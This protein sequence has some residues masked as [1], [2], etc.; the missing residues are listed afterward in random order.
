MKNQEAILDDMP[1]IKKARKRVKKHH[2]TNN[3]P[4]EVS[5]RRQM[6]AELGEDEPTKDQKFVLLQKYGVTAPRIDRLV[7]KPNWKG[8]AEWK[9]QLNDWFKATKG[10]VRPEQR[11]RFNRPFPQ[12]HPSLT[13]PNLPASTVHPYSK[14]FPKTKRWETI[15][16]KNSPS[17]ERNERR[18]QQDTRTFQ[19]NSG[20]MPT[21]NRPN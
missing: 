10:L 6:S 4:V 15:K 3:I 12:T 17:Q 14:V 5:I 8:V 9:R 20:P 18:H 13:L 19:K 16:F 21:E 11:P 7:T 1:P 2:T